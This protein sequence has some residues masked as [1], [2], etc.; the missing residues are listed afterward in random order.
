MSNRDQL[1]KELNKYSKEEIIEAL[2]LSNVA[3]G[4]VL[5][6]CKKNIKPLRPKK[7]LE[8]EKEIK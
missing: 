3:V 1:R 6:H 8:L 2:L 7:S 5:K 4:F